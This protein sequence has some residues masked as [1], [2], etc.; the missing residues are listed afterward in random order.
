[1]SSKQRFDDNHLIVILFEKLR[2]ALQ[3]RRVAI[4]F[5]FSCNFLTSIQQVITR[6]EYISQRSLK[7]ISKV[8]KKAFQKYRK[9]ISKEANKSLSSLQQVFNMSLTNL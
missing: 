4:F 9:R 3:G 2:D 8:S 1:M 7:S 6:H 5:P